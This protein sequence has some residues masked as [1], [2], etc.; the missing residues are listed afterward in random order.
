[1]PHLSKHKGVDSGKR[2][3]RQK[4]VK[5]GACGPSFVA[6]FLNK[7]PLSLSISVHPLPARV[8]RMLLDFFWYQAIALPNAGQPELPTQ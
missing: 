4:S 3:G 5:E 1:M 7:T 8:I 2:R 6:T